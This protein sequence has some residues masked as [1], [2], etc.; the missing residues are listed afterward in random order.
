M[1]IYGRGIR[2]RLAPML[3]NDQ[4]KLRFAYSLLLT[5]PGTPILRYGQEIGMGEDL[6]IK[7]R[8]SVRTLMQ[9]TSQKNG[10]FSEASED[11]L[12]RPILKEGPY[13]Y[14]KNN[15]N[16]QHKKEGSFLN[17]LIRAINLRKESPEFGHGEWETIEV[18]NEAVLALCTKSKRGVGLTLHNFSEE[19][20][21]VKVKVEDSGNLAEF[22]QNKDYDDSELEKMEFTLSPY[23][24]RWFR[25]RKILL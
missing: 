7:G 20:V 24:Y 16:D 15:V 9:W 17:W 1:K 3:N 22:F 10:G 13:G 14:E 21:K 18:E 23:G 12:V 2:R 6:S 8:G 19:E 11:K 4:K 5:L 25:K